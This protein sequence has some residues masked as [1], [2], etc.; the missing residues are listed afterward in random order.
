MPVSAISTSGLTVDYDGAEVLRDIDFS[1]RQQKLT[2][3]VGPNGAGK[4]TL[5]NAM[6]GLIP[7]RTG[8]TTFFDLPLKKFQKNIS[9]VPQRAQIDWEFPASVFDVVAMGLYSELGLLRRFLP[10]HKDR[11]RNALLD[12]DMADCAT[13]QISK[14]S[15]GQQQRVFLARSIVQNSTLVF[16]DEPFAGIDAKS[17]SVIVDILRRQKDDGKSIVAVHHDL[18]TIKNY[19]D[20][21]ILINKSV[22]AHGSVTTVFT[23]E[24]IEKTYGVPDLDFLTGRG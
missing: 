11:I 6:L 19:F 16:L 22:I 9:Y 18:S 10:K 20:D 7:I 2:A 1:V 23:K 15:G 14:L 12:V 13:R 5:I 21:V 3:I 17:E 8:S 24:N 4:S